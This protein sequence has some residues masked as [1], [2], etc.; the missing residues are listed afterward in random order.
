M[1]IHARPAAMVVRITEQ[2]PAATFFVEKDEGAGETGKSIIGT[3]DAGGPARARPV[4]FIAT[5]SDAPQMLANWNSFSAR[6]FDEA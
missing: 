2:I 4:K 6:K 5:A 3:H 1:G